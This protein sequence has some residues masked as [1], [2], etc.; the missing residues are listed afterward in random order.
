MVTV[1]ML[2]GIRLR[3]NRTST[4]AQKQAKSNLGCSCCDFR[5]TSDQS[6]ASTASHT[7][8]PSPAQHPSTGGR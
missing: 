5:V 6:G 3:Q 8:L 7:S 2:H 4:D 1:E